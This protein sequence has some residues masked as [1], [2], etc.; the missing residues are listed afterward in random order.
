MKKVFKTFMSRLRDERGFTLIELMIVIT[1]LGKMGILTS[2]FL[3]RYQR[4]VFFLAF[5]LGAIITPTPDV[6][7]QSMIALPIFVLYEVGYL[8]VR[9]VLRK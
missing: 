4:I 1:I 7:T 2:R 3:Q 6:F 5:V 9:Y 8:I